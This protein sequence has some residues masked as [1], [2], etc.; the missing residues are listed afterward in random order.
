MVGSRAGLTGVTDT[1]VVNL[2]AHLMRLGRSNL[3]VLNRQGLTRRPGNCSLSMCQ[4]LPV[5]VRSVD[6]I[7][8][9]WVG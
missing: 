6:V 8:P 1:S 9:G 7:S 3:D 2:N 5:V 4:Y